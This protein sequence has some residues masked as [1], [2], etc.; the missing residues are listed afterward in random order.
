MLQIDKSASD[1]DQLNLIFTSQGVPLEEEEVL[2][3]LEVV[4]RAKFKSDTRREEFLEMILRTQAAL[5][6]EYDR[7]FASA[8]SS[9]PSS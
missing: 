5:I 7:K 9:G 6:T 4:V 1:S 8:C 3:G 2:G